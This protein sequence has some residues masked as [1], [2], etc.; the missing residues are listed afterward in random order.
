MREKVVKKTQLLILSTL[1][2]LTMPDMTSSQTIEYNFITKY[3]FKEFGVADIT[4]CKW[5]AKG[6]LFAT[7][8]SEQDAYDL[9]FF[10]QHGY[11][12]KPKTGQVFITYMQR[13]RN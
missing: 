8:C 5:D 9:D 2:I 1:I 12:E 4:K 6:W 13:M 3:N 11:E 7:A 10:K